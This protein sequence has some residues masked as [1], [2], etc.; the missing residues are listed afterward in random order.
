M[1]K[2]ILLAALLF[3]PQRA[4]FFSGGSAPSPWTFSTTITIDHTKAPSTQTN[5]PVMFRSPV[6]TVT[7]IGTAVTL[8]TGDQFPTWMQGRNIM[9]NGVVY[10]VSLRVS[11][12]VLTLGSSAGT[13]AV[14]VAYCGT[15]EFATVANGGKATNANGFDVVPFTDSAG[16]TKYDFER[17]RYVAATGEV[18]DW[19]RQGSL[20]AS[21]DTSVY[22]L[23]GNAAVTT[24]QSNKTAVWDANFKLVWHLADN[25]ASTA[26][27]DSTSNANNGTNTANTS[28]KTTTGQINGALGYVHASTELTT[29]TNPV[30]IG[31]GDTTTSFWYKPLQV[32][33]QFGSVGYD[34]VGTPTN[35]VTP[36]LV[37]NNAGQLRQYNATVG[38]GASLQALSSGTLYHVVIVTIAQSSQKA[39]VNG[40]L[41]ETIGGVSTFLTHQGAFNIGASYPDYDTCAVDEVRLSNIARTANWITTEYNNQSAP[42]AFYSMGANAAH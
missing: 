3:T 4:L 28:T 40:A 29:V 19:F 24:D 17:E 9:I 6:G 12:T 21:V 32:A 11:G 15:P 33:A 20:S 8:S 2:Y 38:F 22:Y 42:L 25:A 14:A 16:V 36:M 13:Q 35:S 18:I 7:T 27:L 1:L 39:Y 30:T 34:D 10:A 5:F 23:M 41:A 31:T 37:Q 26:V